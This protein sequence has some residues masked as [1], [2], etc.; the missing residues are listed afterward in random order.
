MTPTF[1]YAVHFTGGLIKVGR[2]AS[3]KFRIATHV[4]RVSCVGLVLLE[5]HVGVCS[6]HGAAAEAALIAR[7]AAGA[8]FRYQN[9]WFRG[10]EFEQV[11][12]WLDEACE[13]ETPTVEQ[14]P[15]PDDFKSLQDELHA[16]RSL[17]ILSVVTGLSRDHLRRIRDGKVVNTTLRTMTRIQDGIKLLQPVADQSP[18]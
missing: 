17:T 5:Q 13:I 14:V 15:V 12:Q 11:S 1:L 3:P 8:A 4:A 18:K 16:V 9:E 2:S 6:G 10:L 7:C